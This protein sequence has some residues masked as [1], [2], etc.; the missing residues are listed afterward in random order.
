MLVSRFN[1]TSRLIA[2]FR[3]LGPYAPIALALP[4]GALIVASLWAFRHRQWFPAHAR[5]LL[6]MVLAHGAT[7]MIPG[8]TFLP[9]LQ[10]AARG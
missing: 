2:A 9:S 6:A 5:R 1:W 7:L 3:E 10:S 4:G 8:C